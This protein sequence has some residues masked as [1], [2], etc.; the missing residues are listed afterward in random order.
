MAGNEKA[1][2]DW[3]FVTPEAY[4]VLL[5]KRVLKKWLVSADEPDIR[6]MKNMI[7]C[8]RMR[9]LLWRTWKRL[10]RD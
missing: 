8:I 4:E 2:L 9:L 1:Q 10:L 7:K 5:A 3:R 6:A